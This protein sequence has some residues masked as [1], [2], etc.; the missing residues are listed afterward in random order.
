MNVLDK[1][2]F[3]AMEEREDVL[4]SE[5]LLNNSGTLVLVKSL[6]QKTGKGNY[7]PLAYV[8]Q[9]VG[10]NGKTSTSSLAGLPDGLFDH[11]A[12]R[13]M[14]N[15]LQFAGLLSKQKKSDFTSI[16]TGEF[17]LAER[18]L[19]N[20][21][22]TEFAKVDFLQSSSD[23]FITDIAKAGIPTELSLIS[24]TRMVRATWFTK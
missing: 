9:Q 19:T 12:W 24:I 4:S 7:A 8:V 18:K 14:E 21:K 2:S 13:L 5:Y 22:E 11:V 15:E 23:K 20:I 17:N 1:F 16:I 6:K 10:S 3:T